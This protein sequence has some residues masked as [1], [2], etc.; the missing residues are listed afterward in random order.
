MEEKF[1]DGNEGGVTTGGR[2]LVCFG[3]FL[4]D[5]IACIWSVEEG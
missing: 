1:D 2:D 5:R 3:K 4:P